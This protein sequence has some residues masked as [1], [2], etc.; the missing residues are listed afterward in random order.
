I[1]DFDHQ[2]EPQ[3]ALRIAEAKEAKAKRFVT[4]DERLVTNSV[5]Q[6]KFEIHI[7]FPWGSKPIE[8]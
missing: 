2:I 8:S 5:L 1:M 3:D 7:E 4:L 6:E